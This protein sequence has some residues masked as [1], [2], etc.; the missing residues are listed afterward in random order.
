MAKRSP[1]ELI[2]LYW[3]EV[4]NNRNAEMI[5]ELC[6]DP[7][8]R[9]DAGSVTALSIEDQIARVRQQSERAEPFFTH[10]VLCAD[11]THVTSVWNM[12]T[13]KGERV[14][15]C[16]IEVFKAVDGKFT[17]CWNSTYV[18]GRWGVEGDSSVPQD[19]PEPA[20][21]GSVDQIT[22]TWVQAMFQHA[23]VPAPRVSL[24]ATRPIGHGNMSQT[25]H[26]QIT[27]NAN[28]ADA[29][30]SVVCKITSAIPQAVDIAGTANVYA[31]ECAVY[32]FLGDTPPLATPRAYWRK[33][34][35]D[36]RAINLVME[37]LSART[38]PG[39]QIS[40]C[41]V[42]EAR[43]VA[44]ELSRLHAAAWGDPRLEGADW[45][46][47]RAGGA[48]DSAQGYAAAAV[49]FRSRY[50]GRTDAAVLDAIDAMVPRMEQA[51]RDAAR[52][53]TLVHGEP[54]VDNVLF[55]DTAGGPRAWLIDWQFATK[56]SP[57]VDLAYFLA[58]SLS[59]EDRRACE[60]GLIEAS[61]AAIAP[62]APHWTLDKARAD[63]AAA[64][65]IALQFTVGAIMAMPSSDH[66]DRLLLTLAERNVAALTDWALV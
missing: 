9:H 58:G 21:I 8:I 65:P 7:I 30:P 34:S 18:P 11:D 20:L 42:D 2:E 44:A 32:E 22:P 4:W 31:R 13:R 59:P 38:R 66:N 47:D 64:L 49:E 54:R 10:E 45:L 5:R 15:L 62:V 14:D 6:A 46:Q 16:G 35:D 52:G 51:I 1:K 43:A 37:D 27:Y 63:Y 57:M 36:G 25:I 3:T 12:H 61:V 19:L 24:L 23:G 26:T 39:D 53:E 28:A 56:A 48:V 17:D 60:A 40:G 55:E 33:V 29:V 41:S 50:A